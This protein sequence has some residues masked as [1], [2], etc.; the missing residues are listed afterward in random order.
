MSAVVVS[1]QFLCLR[2]RLQTLRWARARGKGGNG[3]KSTFGPRELGTYPCLKNFRKGLRFQLDRCLRTLTSFPDP[4]TACLVD[5]R[6]HWIFTKQYFLDN[7]NTMIWDQ[8][9]PWDP[10]IEYGSLESAAKRCLTDEETRWNKVLIHAERRQPRRCSASAATAATPAAATAPIDLERFR[11]F[12]LIVN[13]LTIAEAVR[14]V[15]EAEA[16]EEAKR[17][18]GPDAAILEADQRTPSCLGRLSTSPSTSMAN[19][20]STA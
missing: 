5:S 14:L 17:E 3:N 1:P 19:G 20:I 6:L 8:P 2:R 13:N 16:Q 10:Q 15:A 18:S 4:A 12:A 7:L 9:A 11:R